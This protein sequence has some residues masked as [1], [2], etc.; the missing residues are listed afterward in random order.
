MFGVGVWKNVALHMTLESQFGPQ[1]K[2]VA[3]PCAKHH[4]F[5]IIEA[6]TVELV[7]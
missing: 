5:V 3:H 6:I 2:K 4:N 1:L 7:S